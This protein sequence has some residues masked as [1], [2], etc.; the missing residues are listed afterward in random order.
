MTKSCLIICL[1]ESKCNA[2]GLNTDCICVVFRL[3]MWNSLGY[4]RFNQQIREEKNDY[5]YWTYQHS[6]N[7]LC[8]IWETKAQNGNQTEWIFFHS[9]NNFCMNYSNT[10]TCYSF[11]SPCMDSV[12]GSEMIS[13]P[14]LCIYWV[15]ETHI[16][17]ASSCQRLVHHQLLPSAQL[18]TPSRLSARSDWTE[19]WG[20]FSLA[21]RETQVPL[22]KAFTAQQPQWQTPG[23]SCS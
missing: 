12:M 15:V 16:S 7:F 23:L 17:A 11:F 9:S 3:W 5:D 18:I 21:A 22:S 10:A 1:M 20:E 14:G 8:S 4:C 19:L 13:E 2:I 6:Y